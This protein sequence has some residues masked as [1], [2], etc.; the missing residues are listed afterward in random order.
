MAAG[1]VPQ[2]FRT[3][4]L[5]QMEALSFVNFLTKLAFSPITKMVAEFIGTSHTQFS[6]SEEATILI[7]ELT[8]SIIKA[9]SVAIL[10]PWFQ[11]PW[12]KPWRARTA[13]IRYLTSILVESDRSFESDSSNHHSFVMSVPKA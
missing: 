6:D 8:D 13:L 5:S 12:S 1:H 4:G 11:M 10:P 2:H 7:Q 3:A 9:S